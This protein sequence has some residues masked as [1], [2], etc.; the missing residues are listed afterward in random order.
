MQRTSL[1][2]THLST[3]GAA[4]QGWKQWHHLTDLE[5]TDEDRE[6]VQPGEDRPDL[7]G[8]RSGE[9]FDAFG[10]FHARGFAPERRCGQ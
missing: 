5:D 3:L 4:Q 2:H 6:Q 7:P 8:K 10:N 9:R 1:E